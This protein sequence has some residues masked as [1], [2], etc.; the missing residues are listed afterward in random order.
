MVTTQLSEINHTVPGINLPDMWI[1]FTSI[2]Q[3][4][5]KFNGS[6][7][8][9]VPT[10]RLQ[11]ETQNYGWNESMER[12]KRRV[13]CPS[14]NKWWV[15]HKLLSVPLHRRLFI[16]FLGQQKS[17]SPKNLFHLPNEHNEPYLSLK[18]C[19]FSSQG[20]SHRKRGRGLER[21]CFSNYSTFIVVIFGVRKKSNVSTGKGCNGL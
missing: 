9:N 14:V 17:S 10:F 13:V 2:F 5:T 15:D 1:L 7:V 19:F 12:G 21:N 16:I 6:S 20:Y 11:L 4:Q 8:F 18:A 3:K